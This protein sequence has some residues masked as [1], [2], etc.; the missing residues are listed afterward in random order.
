[1]HSWNC[2]MRLIG[3]ALTG[4]TEQLLAIW[5]RCGVAQHLWSERAMQF[6]WQRLG[7][8][9]SL[10]CHSNTL[11]ITSVPDVRYGAV[12]PEKLVL[13][14]ASSSFCL[15]TLMSSTNFVTLIQR[16]RTAQGITWYS[17]LKHSY[18][19]CV[20]V[21]ETMV[22]AAKA[23]Y[24]GAPLP[25]QEHFIVYF[26]DFCAFYTSRRSVT[27]AEIHSWYAEAH[28]K[29]S[30]KTARIEYGS[31]SAQTGQGSGDGQSACGSQGGHMGASGSKY[32]IGLHQPK[33]KIILCY[34]C[35]RLDHYSNRCLWKVCIRNQEIPADAANGQRPSAYRPY[36]APTEKDAQ[37]PPQPP[38]PRA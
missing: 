24:G 18:S 15:W 36:V 30:R 17:R 29:R 2:W 5:Y 12:R 28:A 9:L 20:A 13:S 31:A 23:G 26:S 25:G 33:G 34:R 35:G 11:Q 4:C 10:R 3:I 6:Y 19:F 16:R 14:A 8:R 38:P 37:A 32:G 27:D 7:D 22:R 1:M 21:K